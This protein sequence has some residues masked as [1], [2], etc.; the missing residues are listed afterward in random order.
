MTKKFAFVAFPLILLAALFAVTP[1][2]SLPKKTMATAGHRIN[3]SE[4]GRGVSTKMTSFDDA[5]QRHMGVLDVLKD[6]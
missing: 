5:Y 3:V 4:V 6:P 1:S 2:L